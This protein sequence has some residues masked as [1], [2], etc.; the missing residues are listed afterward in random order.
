MKQWT[1]FVT[2]IQAFFYYIGQQMVLQVPEL[3]HWAMA[4]YT[5]HRPRETYRLYG[6][7]SSCRVPCAY[8]QFY[9][10][11]QSEF[12]CFTYILRFCNILLQR[13]KN[14]K[15]RYFEVCSVQRSRFSIYILSQMAYIAVNHFT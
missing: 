4:N 3:S 15:Y 14:L 10:F 8:E 1:L 13:L 12:L 5:E 11:T 9:C 7:F 6:Y 2:S